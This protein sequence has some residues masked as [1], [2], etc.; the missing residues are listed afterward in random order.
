MTIDW[1]RYREL[2]AM[3]GDSFHRETYAEIHKNYPEQRHCTLPS[4]RRFLTDH[5]KALVVEMGGWDGWAASVMLPEFPELEH[6]LNVEFCEDAAKATVCDDK[7]FNVYVPRTFQWWRSEVAPAASDVM[8][9]SH[10]IEHLTNEDAYEL[11]GSL[12]PLAW[13]IEAPLSE[14][15][16]DWS[17][18]LGTHVLRAGWVELEKWLDAAGYRR[19]WAE[20]DARS[21]SRAR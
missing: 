7:R 3:K 16:Q 14:N 10:V 19:T 4:L 8:V 11:I 9:L 17:G 20:G 13:Y 15:G 21:Y 18:Y 5:H 2:Y 6:W 1:D 12:R